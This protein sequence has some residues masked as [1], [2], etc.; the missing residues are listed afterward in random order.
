MWFLVPDC[1]S[2]NMH[3]IRFSDRIRDLLV[4]SLMPSVICPSGENVLV[5]A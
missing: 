4:T 5:I 2:E 1:V 3:E